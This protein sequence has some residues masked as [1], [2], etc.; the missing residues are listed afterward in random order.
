M[1]PVG[2]IQP[3]LQSATRELPAPDEAEI[4]AALAHIETKQ[5]S[6]IDESAT[7]RDLEDFKQ[8]S[9]KRLLEVGVAEANKRKK[10]RTAFLTRYQD[11]SAAHRDYAKHSYNVE[12]E[13][14]AWQQVQSQEI[15]EEKERKKDMQRKRRRE[16]SMAATIE[17]KEAALA[18]A[19]AAEDEAERQKHLREAA[20]AGKKAEQ[21]K[22]VLQESFAKTIAE[23]AITTLL[24]THSITEAVQLSDRIVVMTYRPGRVKRIVDIDLPRPRTSDI[25]SSSSS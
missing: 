18:K 9:Q 16:K 10:R 23:A 14:D 25:V 5:M 22:L 20:R 2:T 19:N 4:E 13:G 3:P 12:H 15:A 6:D 8:K 17:Q 1:P 7:P 24:I 11:V 21:T